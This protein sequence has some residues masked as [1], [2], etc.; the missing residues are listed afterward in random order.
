MKRID[1]YRKELDKLIEANG[2]DLSNEA[3]VKKSLEIEKIL[4]K[5][6]KERI[7]N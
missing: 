6:E 3:V 4:Y 5:A 1:D 2:F 7:H